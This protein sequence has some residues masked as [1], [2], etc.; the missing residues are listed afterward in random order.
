MVRL[1]A[2]KTTVC[3]HCVSSVISSAW[4]ARQSTCHP[5]YP[6]YIPTVFPCR[7]QGNPG[8]KMARYECTPKK[9]CSDQA[10]SVADFNSYPSTFMSDYWP[11]W[12]SGGVRRWNANRTHHEGHCCSAARNWGNKVSETRN[13]AVDQLKKNLLGKKWS[14]FQK[15]QELWWCGLIK[16]CGV[17]RRISIRNSVQGSVAAFIVC[18]GT[19]TKAMPGCRAAA[20][21]DAHETAAW[22]SHQ[23]LR[24]PVQ[25][26]S[27]YHEQHLPLIAWRPNQALYETY[28]FAILMR[29]KSWRPAS[30][31]AHLIWQPRRF[32]WLHRN[33]Y[34][35]PN[36]SQSSESD[37]V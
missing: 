7:A 6:D 28:H 32:N 36:F 18:L 34:S 14:T 26:F 31:W 10:D 24:M 29:T 16:L 27:R 35:A 13:A 1:S 19:T 17:L 3:I 2:L 22:T 37:L 25:H 11:L 15:S 8:Q 9:S 33:I 4:F 21:S 5:N 12:P 20:A 30:F 23:W